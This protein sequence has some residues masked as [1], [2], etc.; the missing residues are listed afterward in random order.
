MTTKR[1]WHHQV[2]HERLPANEVYETSDGKTIRVEYREENGVTYKTT[3]TY[4]S[5]K[6]KVLPIVAERKKWKKIR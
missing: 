6:L 2:E 5:Q 3:K 4:K 1:D